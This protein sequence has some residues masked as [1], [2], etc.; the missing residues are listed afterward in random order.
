VL[1]I[2]CLRLRISKYIANSPCEA[3]E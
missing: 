1:R 3:F 2:T